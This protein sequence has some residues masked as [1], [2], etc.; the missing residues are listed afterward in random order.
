MRG[1]WIPINTPVSV[2]KFQ[3][4]STTCQYRLGLLLASAIRLPAGL[5]YQV[6]QRVQFYLENVGPYR[7]IRNSAI[8]ERKSCSLPYTGIRSGCT[9]REAP[10]CDYFNGILKTDLPD[11]LLSAPNIR[12][13]HTSVK[14]ARLTNFDRKGVQSFS[15]ENC[16]TYCIENY[17]SN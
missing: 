1:G 7:C 4:V 3:R 13:R 2:S 12:L 16:F 11:L 9:H 14:M 17:N 6:F 8:S 10:P 5:L 15:G